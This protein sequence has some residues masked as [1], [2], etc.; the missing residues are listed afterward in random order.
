LSP[1]SSAADVAI[2]ISV[3]SSL[4]LGTIAE[5]I[6]FARSRQGALN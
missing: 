6:A 1:I 4:N 3:P 2:A 5:F